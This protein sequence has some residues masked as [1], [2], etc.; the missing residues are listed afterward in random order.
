MRQIHLKIYIKCPAEWGPPQT[1]S[2]NTSRNMPLYMQAKSLQSCLTMTPW[3][4]V[5]QVPLSMGFSRQE[6]WSGL[7]CPPPGDIPDPGIKPA[8]L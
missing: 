2:L 1:V 8:F 7:P 4:V 6:S 3:T 5:L